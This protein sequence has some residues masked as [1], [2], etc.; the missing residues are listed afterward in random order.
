MGN[1]KMRAFIFGFIPMTLMQ[2]LYWNWLIHGITDKGIG[3]VYLL[4]IA[5]VIATLIYVAYERFIVYSVIYQDVTFRD[6][7]PL[8][9]LW[10]LESIIAEIISGNT[11]WRYDQQIGRLIAFGS[12]FSLLSAIGMIVWFPIFRLILYWGIKNEN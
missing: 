7:I 8:A 6:R 9:V 5:P 2:C 1:K 4:F 10:I 12:A 11:I 3:S